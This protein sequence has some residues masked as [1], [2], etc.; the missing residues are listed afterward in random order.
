[1]AVAGYFSMAQTVAQVVVKDDPALAASLAPWDGRILA[2]ALEG[3]PSSS[4]SATRSVQAL[5]ALRKDPTAVNAVAHLGLIAQVSGDLAGARRLFGYSERLSRRDLQTQLW[6]IEDAVGRDDIAGALRH[7]DVA[8]RTKVQ[9]R[10]I[11]Y[12]VLASA[13][14]DAQVRAELVRTMGTRPLWADDFLAYASKAGETSEATAALLVALHRG[15][16]PVPE[17]VNST[18]IGTMVAG[19]QVEKA[20][21]FYRGFRKHADRRRARDPRFAAALEAPTVFDWTPVNDGSVTGSIQPS[22]SS[23]LFDFYVV[24]G[25]G[26][27][28]LKQMQVLPPGTYRLR[29][30]SRGIEQERGALPYWSLLCGSRELGRVEVPNS[31]EAGGSFTGVLSVPAGCPVQTLVL[32]GRPSD[33]V[34]GL[35][36][37]IHR[38]ELGPAQ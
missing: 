3:V 6:A 9:S 15:G 8:L 19:G 25:G 2:A 24:P 26:G 37:Q 10:A 36:G 29:G 11:L 14:G 7:Y 17:H 16:I 13:I 22:G 35:M 28:L 21:D 20:W 27:A 1:L 31:A 12:P 34:A 23:G 4:G 32:I 33:S 18:L 5:D 38:L 30:H